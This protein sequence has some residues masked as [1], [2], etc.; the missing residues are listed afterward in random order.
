MI[1][2]LA[3][4]LFV[5]TSS[6]GA[7]P[8]KDYTIDSKAL[9][10]L[11][12]AFDIT[13]NQNIVE[14]TQKKWLRKNGQER[15]EVDKLD[16][17]LSNFVLSWANE[18]GFF[19][20]RTPSSLTYD[21]AFIL[22]ATTSRMKMR[23]EHLK[24]LWIN[25]IR[26]SEV[27]WL[28]GERPL[29]ERVD[30]LLDLCKTESDA[31]KIVWESSDLP[32]DMANLPV[33]FISVP[34]KIEKGNL[35]RPNTADTI[36]AYVEKAKDPI[37]ALFISNQPYCNYQFAVIKKFLPEEFIFDIAGPGVDS[38]N[39]TINAAVI[40]DSIARELYLSS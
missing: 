2:Q 26:F 24:K 20:E 38:E 22:G 10:E 36:L 23:L 18:N 29:D 19:E 15:W 1:K 16:S 32:Q 37:K 25:G 11:A 28:T 13:D 9:S 27:V 40:L 30:T 12:L 35:I 21:K 8:I 4:F 6:L 33:T 39:S 5:L 7:T 34:M 3:F 17:N 14:E 31:A